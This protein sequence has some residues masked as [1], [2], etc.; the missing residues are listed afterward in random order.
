MIPDVVEW[1]Q[2]GAFT[3]DELTFVRELLQGEGIARR[4]EGP[5]GYRSALV[6]VWVPSMQHARAQA[7]LAQAQAEAA[8][9]AY[10]ETEAPA[11]PA[12]ARRAPPAPRAIDR[13]AKRRRRRSRRLRDVPSA[14]GRGVRVLGGLIVGFILVC[15]L[16]VVIGERY[17]SQYPRL[18]EGR[19]MVCSTNR[20]G[21]TCR[22]P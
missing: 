20:S 6:E 3:G 2:L 15:V 8:A 7:R 9:A 5:H 18:H 12:P 14:S 19:P 4:E 11:E 13:H 17:G 16:I 21:T 10:R 1:T 22:E